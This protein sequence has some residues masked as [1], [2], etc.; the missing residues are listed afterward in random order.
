LVVLISSEIEAGAQGSK[1][2]SRRARIADVS[3]VYDP[4]MVNDPNVS[5]SDPRFRGAA[6][7]RAQILLDRAHF[8]PG[9]IDGEPGA[10]FERSLRAFQ[11]SRGI[12]PSGKLDDPTWQTLNADT[13]PV[14]APYRITPEDVAGPFAPIPKDI[15][16]QSKLAVLGY[17]SALEALGEQF[18]IKP[19]LLQHLNAGKNVA[20][21]EEIT[22]PNVLNPAV[23]K[24]SQIIVTKS[25]MLQA[26][27]SS[28]KVIAHYPCSSG[29]L[30]DPLP[31]GKWRVNGIAKHPPF[32]YNP[33]LFWDADPQHSKAK[34]APGPNN[35][36]G[37]AWI[38]LSKEHYGIHGTPTPSK[39]GHTQSHGCIRLTN[40]DVMELASLISAGTSA[41][42]KE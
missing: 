26:L 27:D 4:A 2:R 11:K 36:I 40:W 21:G 39:V 32:H 7:L 3:V 34:I 20:T 8:S 14:L 22:V 42:L 16:E 25:G 17:E 33:S 15:M 41:V 12:S 19:E 24:A 18:H 6:T 9:E 23:G 10:N 35:P 29:S 30:H 28:G 5:R 13:A 38:D 37:L 1:G 31:L